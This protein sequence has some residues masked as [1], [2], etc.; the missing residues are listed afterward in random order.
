MCTPRFSRHRARPESRATAR[1]KASRPPATPPDGP[2]FRL[3]GQKV[4]VAKTTPSFSITPTTAAVMPVSAACSLGLAV[5]RSMYGAPAKTRKKLG[6]NMPKV[7]KSPPRTPAVRGVSA[8][9]LFQAVMKPVNCVTM[10]SGPGVV[11][12]R[13]R[14]STSCSWVSQPRRMDMS[15]T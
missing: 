10:I 1:A 15:D 6:R 7:V 3:A 4:A 8:P 12:A 2:P 5:R 9:G 14:P 11:S 13:P